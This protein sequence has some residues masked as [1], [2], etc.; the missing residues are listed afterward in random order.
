[1]LYT[2][3]KTYEDACNV[4]NINPAEDLPYANPANAKQESLN[5]FAKLETIV[6]AINGDE[7]FPDWT[8]SNQWKYYP[9]FWM[10]KASKTVSGL[11]LSYFDY[12]CDTSVSYVGSRLVF[13][14]KEKAKYAA[15]QFN[16]IYEKFMQK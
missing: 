8:N 6:K 14:S 7:A 11:G 1:M 12:V 4:L 13:D 15:N 16:D 5:A 3:I 9:W 10:N 2:D